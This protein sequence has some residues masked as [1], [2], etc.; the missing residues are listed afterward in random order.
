MRIWIFSD[1]H[2]YIPPALTAPE[3]VDVIVVAGDTCEGGARMVDVLD[4]RFGGSG[5]HIVTVLGN[6]EFYH[7]CVDRE[8]R[9]AR[10]RGDELG[11]TVLD[12]RV[13]EI[14]DAVRFVGCTLWTDYMLYAGGSEGHQRAYMRA[15]A[16][17]LND[18]RLVQLSELSSARF[19]PEHARALHLEARAFLEMVLATP[20]GGPTVVVTHHCPHPR[21]VPD[22][23]VGDKL[24]P[25]FCSDL[26]NIIERFQPAMWIHGHTHSS[27]DY[28][29][30]RTRVICNPKGYGA[31]NPEFKWDLVVEI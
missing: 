24:T 20:F 22:V 3:G 30:G 13:V 29:V 26:S 28:M 6:H 19:R 31:E 2:S 12:N 11:V 10:K 7:G 27:F 16:L 21:S 1:L 14:D 9:E 4:T 17:G 25:A 18:H 15:A 5:A 8:R 23:F